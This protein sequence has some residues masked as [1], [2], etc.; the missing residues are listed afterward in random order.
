MGEDLWA[1]CAT[2]CTRRPRRSTLES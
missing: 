1:E 2:R